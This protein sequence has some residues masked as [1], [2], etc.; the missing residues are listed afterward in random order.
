MKTTNITLPNLGNLNLEIKLEG[1][2]NK[3]NRLTD[4]LG[5]SIESGYNIAIN[6]FSKR[7][8][9]IV[10]NCISTGTPPRG[11]NWEPLSSATIRRYGNHDLFYLTGL[12]YRS[13]GLY[14]YKSRTLIGMPINKKRSSQGGITLGGLAR[15]LEYGTY[16]KGSGRGKG[17][18]PPRPLWA[19]SFKQLNG[20]NGLRKEILTEIRRQLY[21]DFGIRANQVR[22]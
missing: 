11:V 21:R 20:M 3:V 14:R 18:I 8:L 10:K 17:A 22:W 7:L 2:W 9:R 5:N 19:P 13:I 6:K 15:I 12:Y 16:S 4:G 1:D